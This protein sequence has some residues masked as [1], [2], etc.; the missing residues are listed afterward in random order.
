MEEK[1][2]T[3][4]SFSCTCL[5]LQHM[6]QAHGPS[7]QNRSQPDHSRHLK[8]SLLCTCSFHVCR[9]FA[10]LCFSSFSETL[11]LGLLFKA[12]EG[13]LKGVIRPS[14]DLIQFLFSW[15]SAFSFSSF[16][17]EGSN[18]SPVCLNLYMTVSIV[19]SVWILTF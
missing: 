16:G 10:L 13:F 6:Q 3:H 9:M 4:I 12:S 19:I 8:W 11:N 17:G 2:T 1:Q 15:H 14:T 7:D 5:D 18:N